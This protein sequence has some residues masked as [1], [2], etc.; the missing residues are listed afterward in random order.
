MLLFVIWKL[1]RISISSQHRKPAW[2]PWA[3]EAH[4]YHGIAYCRLSTN[5]SL[6][7]KS[8]FDDVVN[9][10]CA[11]IRNPL[12]LVDDARDYIFSITNGH[13][14]A[15]DA[16]IETLTKVCLVCIPALSLEAYPCLLVVSHGDQVS[17]NHRGGQ[18]HYI[19]FEWRGKAIQISSAFEF[20]AVFPPSDLSDEAAQVLRYTLANQSIPLNHDDPGIESCYENGWLH[21]EPL[22]ERSKGVVCIF[23]S[24]LHMKWVFLFLTPE[25]FSW[26]KQTDLSN[27]TLLAIF[28][29]FHSINFR[30][31]QLWQQPFWRNFRRELC[32]RQQGWALVVKWYP[33]NLVSK[34]SFIECCKQFLG[35]LQR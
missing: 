20:W 27:I 2:L 10:L 21:S 3:W 30:L 34:T 15:V 32:Y 6:L 8:E 35:F 18:P 5:Q 24:K 7:Q 31:L 4:F 23:P 11:D 28:S 29:P 9:R 33:L 25:L 17:R 1:C 16:F 26:L 19:G 13:P 14:G 12:P 22:D